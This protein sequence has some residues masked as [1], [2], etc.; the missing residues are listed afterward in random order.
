MTAIGGVFWQVADLLGF[1]SRPYV[2]DDSERD[3]KMPASPLD[4]RELM[5]LR[6]IEQAVVGAERCD[7]A[8]SGYGGKPCKGLERGCQSCL[9]LTA[10]AVAESLG[11]F[12][13]RR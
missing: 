4:P 11:Q 9:R 2:R 3:G 12:D 8:A 5:R 1:I 10:M 6:V 13:R 7:R